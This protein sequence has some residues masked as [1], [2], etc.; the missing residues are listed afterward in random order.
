MPWS[1]PRWMLMLIRS[2]PMLSLCSNSFPATD[3]ANT[4]P[5]DW[6]WSSDI[7]DK[8]WSKLFLLLTS[9]GSKNNLLRSV[10]VTPD[11]GQQVVVSLE[12]NKFKSL[13][14][15]Y[16]NIKTSATLEPDCDQIWELLLR[17]PQKLKDQQRNH[18]C[19]LLIFDSWS[20]LP[21]W[22]EGTLWRWCVEPGRW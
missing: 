16:K 13:K 18:S 2:I 12:I 11:L 7:P 4:V 19:L 3:E 17:M 14:N 20:S 10:R 8:H 15:I 1:L 6:I 5:G 21:E 9:D 22:E